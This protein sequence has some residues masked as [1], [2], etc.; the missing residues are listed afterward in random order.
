MDVLKQAPWGSKG[1]LCAGA[2]QQGLLLPMAG[3]LLT[4]DGEFARRGAAS[5]KS[6]LE[7][8]IDA[9]TFLPRNGRQVLC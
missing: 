1:C 5:S 3:A 9:G 6:F 8:D 4:S 2:A 7:E